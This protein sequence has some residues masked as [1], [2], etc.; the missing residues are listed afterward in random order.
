MT[1]APFWCVVNWNQRFVCSANPNML[2][3]NDDGS[4][5]VNNEA[6]IRAFTE[7]LE[8]LAF[9][10]PGALA[11]GLARPVPAHGSRQ[12]PEGGSFPN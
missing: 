6:G 9:H 5:N 8:N 3:F 11:E 10:G 2:Y 1:Y 12:R 4:A 7:I